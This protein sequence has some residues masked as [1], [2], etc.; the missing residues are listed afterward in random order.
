MSE[1]GSV[2][3]CPHCKTSFHVGPIQLEAAQGHVRCGGCLKVFDANKH[4]LIEQ[5][6]LFSG[7]AEEPVIEDEISIIPGALDE[8]DADLMPPAEEAK[9]AFIDEPAE[10]QTEAQVEEQ[11]ED[12]VE[13]Q[14]EFS[15]QELDEPLG[16]SEEDKPTESIEEEDPEDLLQKQDEVPEADD[17]IE[18]VE[19]EDLD[20]ELGKT[21]SRFTDIEEVTEAEIEAARDEIIPETLKPAD[22]GDEAIDHI[23]DEAF[24]DLEENLA[25]DQPREEA[26]E[27]EIQSEQDWQPLIAERTGAK[28]EEPE[29][30]GQ[31]EIDEEEQ[32]AEQLFVDS[33]KRRATKKLSAPWVAGATLLFVAL[34]AQS[35]YWQPNSLRQYDFYNQVSLNYC[36]LLP[37]REQIL[38]DL[39]QLYITGLVR[40]SDEYN[41]ALSVQVEL[42]NRADQAQQFPHI[43]LAFTDLR[44]QKISLRR[45]SPLEYLR[46]ETAG[47]TVLEP[48]QRV[49]IEMEL[50]DPGASAI[51]YEFNLLYL[52]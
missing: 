18:Q 39:S 3:Q 25:A 5:K 34:F 21:D 17:N 7:A 2:T 30:F 8:D 49:Q 50:Y 12:Q 6:P 51:S 26:P 33:K 14:E 16:L 36:A 52:N 22:E 46:A 35:M 41:N 47:R 11:T 37:C 13:E 31:S 43:E 44:G 23:L 19:E 20:E 28:A 42:R 48:F 10:E 9:D 40:P 38:Q 15:D 27:Q 24:D 1:Y 32:L 45:F 29:F 4:F